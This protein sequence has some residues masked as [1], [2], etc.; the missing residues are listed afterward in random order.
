MLQSSAVIACVSTTDL[1]RGRDF[2]E[3]VL[4]LR[5]TEK[6]SFACVFDANGTMLRLTAAATVAT[7][8]YTV[9]GWNVSDIAA[10]V[11]DL[12][13]RGVPVNRY[14]GMDQDEDGVWTTPSGDRVAWFSDPDGNVL[15][16]TQF[17]AAASVRAGE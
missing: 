1:D 8:G 11:A 9:L 5:V 15:S 6:N 13:G 7:P 3:R 17:F 10:T 12:A 14:E 16:L 2:Y 4:G